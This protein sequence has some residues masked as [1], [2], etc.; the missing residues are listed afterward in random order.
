M[1][2]LDE[3]SIKLKGKIELQ[4]SIN[5]NIGLST[6]HLLLKGYRQFHV[7]IE[8]YPNRCSINVKVNSDLL[9]SVNKPDYLFG[10]SQPNKLNNFPYVVYR[11]EHKY[12]SSQNEALQKFWDLLSMLLN[13]FK[14]NVSEC[15]F[16]YFNKVIFV[17]D[18]KRDVGSALDQIIDFLNENNKVFKRKAPAIKINAKKIP[19]NIKAV[20][21]F[22]KKYSIS[23]DS[24]R[25]ELVEQMSNDEKTTLKETI[26]PIMS[27]IEA[28]LDSF[29]NK[30]FTV[31]ASLI[32]ELA[33]LVAELRFK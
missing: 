1:D 20:I 31:E 9:F 12:I 30:A 16:F 21:P 15:V 32:L 2:Y 18:K 27:E 4:D 19:D 28:Y 26:F 11:Q 22:L 24:E 23:D 29:K 8:D 14:L 25:G 7:K 5:A 33:E 3:L 10:C 13:G 6:R 17:L